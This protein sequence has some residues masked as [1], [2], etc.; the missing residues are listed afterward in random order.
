[1]QTAHLKSPSHAPEITLEM[2][3]RAP[4]LPKERL[5]NHRTAA[6]YQAIRKRLG[7]KSKWLASQAA[8]DVDEQDASGWLLAE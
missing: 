6:N 1:M 8:S 2:S 5:S 4:L 7:K 3:H